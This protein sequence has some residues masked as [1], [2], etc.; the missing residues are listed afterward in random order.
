[1]D[2]IVYILAAH[3]S[4]SILCVLCTVYSHIYEYSR[5]QLTHTKWIC[6]FE[7]ICLPFSPS[8]SG[9]H[10]LSHTSTMCSSSSNSS[11][12]EWCVR[13]RPVYYWGG[14]MLCIHLLF[15]N[16]CRSNGIL[17]YYTFIETSNA[18]MIS[19]R[20]AAHTHP[21]IHKWT[22]LNLIA[23]ENRPHPLVNDAILS[24]CP[25]KNIRM[26]TE[27]IK[28][29]LFINEYCRWRWWWW[30][31][32]WIA[33]AFRRMID[34]LTMKCRFIYP[35]ELGML[36]YRWYLMLGGYY[37]RM[38]SVRH[39]RQRRQRRQCQRCAK[40][41]W[42]NSSLNFFACILGWILSGKYT[43]RRMRFA[44]TPNCISRV[45][46]LAQAQPLTHSSIHIPYDV[47]IYLY[48]YRKRSIHTNTHISDSRH[49]RIYTY[50]IS[51]ELLSSKWQMYSYEI[52]KKMPLKGICGRNSAWCMRIG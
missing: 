25:I 10:T 48:I 22:N 18:W 16:L 9:L 45:Q 49:S 15:I 39:D 3:I 50:S 35:A 26:K 51:T 33:Q 41:R 34:K 21:S 7:D 42:R 14:R 11:S 1:M 36:F 2:N 5:I 52:L 27:S 32:W 6:T 19:A 40:L 4:H 8:P 47:R 29:K 31:W 38:C 12:S 17:P 28:S 37:G 13:V 30:W 46:T 23:D 20:I 44:R 24:N 43:P